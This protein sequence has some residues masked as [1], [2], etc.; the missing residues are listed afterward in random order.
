MKKIIS[1]LAVAA[2]FSAAAFAQGFQKGDKKKDNDE[3]WREKVRAEQVAFI[4]SELDLTEAE[5]QK[6]WPV[7]NDIQSKRR[8]AYKESF[9]AMKELKEQLDKGDDSGVSL[10][11]YLAAKKKIQDLDDDAVKQYSKVLSKNK[12]AKL[13]L[14]EERFRHNQIGKLGGGKGPG[15]QPRPGGGF[16]PGNG[17]FQEM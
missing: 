15:K 2:M 12:V 4:T 16:R 13:I 3:G 5:A 8:E 17:D 11:K 9:E 1:I 6:F 14:S 7:Y 10:D